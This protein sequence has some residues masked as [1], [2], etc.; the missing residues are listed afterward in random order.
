VA[1]F[2]LTR[3]DAIALGA[4]VVVVGGLSF[5]TGFLTATTMMSRPEARLALMSLPMPPAAEPKTQLAAASPGGALVGS[6]NA[7]PSLPPGEAARL[8]GE[9]SVRAELPPAAPATPVP[10]AAVAQQTAPRFASGGGTIGG[11]SD[12]SLT[13]PSVSTPSLSVGPSGVSAAQPSLQGPSLTRPAFTAPRAPTFTTGSG[14]TFRAP[15]AAEPPAPAPM[16]V[17]TGVLPKAAAE[18]AADAKPGEAPAADGKA[19]DS[20]GADSKAKAAEAE[21]KAPPRQLPPPAPK[22][23]AGKGREFTAQVGAFRSDENAAAL[24]TELDRRGVGLVDVVAQFDE[25]ERAWYLVRVGRFADRFEAS[26]MVDRLRRENLPAMLIEQPAT[27]AAQIA[28][29]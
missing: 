15:P 24:A 29:K 16:E 7:T 12:P 21:K 10:A 26:A 22:F 13:G 20:K 17:A 1:A 4:G 2:T 9:S 3:R 6:A 5:L 25:A 11:V 8:A 27:P 18:K 28:S 19:G 14:T 23:G